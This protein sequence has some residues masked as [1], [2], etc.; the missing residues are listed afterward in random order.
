MELHDKIMLPDLG[1]EAVLRS[2]KDAEY[3][4]LDNTIAEKNTSLDFYYNR[5]LD[6]HIQQ[7]F[8][9]ESLS[10]IPPVLMSLVKRFAK[11]RLMLLKQPAERFINGEFNDY[12][13]EKTHN[14]NT[15][16]R[17]FG[18]L[19]WLLGSCHLQSM[20][21]PKTQRIEYKIHPIV[22]EYVYDGEVYGVSYEIHRDFNGDRQFAFWSK[23]LD[24]EQGMHFRF[25][26]NGKMMP[27]GNNLEMVNPYNLIPLSKV[28]FNTSASDVTRCAVHASNA[29]TEVMIATRLMM[30]SPVITGLDT[31]IPPYLKFGVDRLIALPE[32]ASMQYVS[33]SANL[34]QMI[35]SVKDLINQ[36]GQNH[37]LTIRWGESSAPP[38]G[39]ALKILSV[40][41]IETR[42]S[43]IPVFRDFEHERYEIDRELLSVHEGTN[44]SEKYSV[45]YP[46]VGFPMTWTEE[47][48]KLEFMMEHN[49]ITRE[50][51]VRKFNPDI[52]EAEL[53]LKMEELEPEQPEQPT[54]P[55]LEALQRG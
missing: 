21:N 23:P 39:E 49:L 42:E 15:K 28:E 38:S 29:W 45:D 55:L 18:E 11:S 6:E 47:R 35:Q 13:T 22:K 54:N 19:A 4:A 7:Y 32:G 24:G 34:G 3:S 25:N 12:Y 9:T 26:V 50:E 20:Y 33:P 52:D 5:N 1:K 36:V 27:V 16:V 37:S 40:D 31:E 2:V 17:E 10:Q 30:G 14:L 44:L 51:L 43:D 46:E 48:N 8:S 53:A 41:N